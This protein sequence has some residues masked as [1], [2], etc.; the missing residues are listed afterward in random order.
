MMNSALEV[1]DCILRAPFGGEVATR[2]EDPGA[3]VRPGTQI[4]SV[5]DRSIVRVVG[6]APEVD[7]E[8][9]AP[10]TV[11]SVHVLAT[12]KDFKGVIARCAPAADPGTRTVHFE[13][14]V[15]D[16]ERTAPRGH[17]GRDHHRRR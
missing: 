16:P 13:I 9:L 7:F 5:V 15:P 12:N 14:D 1:N 10:G 8:A 17:D 6:D 3:F 2:T 4:V 11:A